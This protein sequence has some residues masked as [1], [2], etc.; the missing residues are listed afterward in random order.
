MSEVRRTRRRRVML[1]LVVVLGFVIHELA[2]RALI[3]HGVAGALLAGG[4]GWL[5]VVAAAAFLL[6]RL[7]AFVVVASLP[8]L[9]LRPIYSSLISK[10]RGG[11]GSPSK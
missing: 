11:L 10:M 9:L 8:V 5:T 4:G 6:L 1:A 3:D 7:A 2:A